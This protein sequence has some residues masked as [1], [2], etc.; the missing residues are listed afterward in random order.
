[1]RSLKRWGILAVITIIGF[2]LTSCGGEEE[3]LETGHLGNKLSLSGQVYDT[4]WDNNDNPIFIKINANISIDPEGNAGGNGSVKN[5]KL[6]FNIG[7]P[8]ANNLTDINDLLETLN[9]MGDY[10]NVKSNITSVKA[11]RLNNIFTDHSQLARGNINKKGNEQN[12][13]SI[14][15]DVTYVYVNKDV[16]ITAKG[17]KEVNEDDDWKYTDNFKDICLSLKKGWNVIYQKNNR[18]WSTNNS[19]FYISTRTQTITV[20]NPSSMKWFL[21]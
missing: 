20:K 6:S 18:V 13:S 4:E 2:T 12:G 19:G 14:Y 21:D 7:T 5:G 9:A 1:M 8:A 3:D 16:K 15:E 10:A 17:D 11:Y